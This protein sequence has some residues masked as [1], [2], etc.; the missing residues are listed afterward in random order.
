MN[1]KM[2]KAYLDADADSVMLC[3]LDHTIVYMN[4]SAITHFARAGGEALV[5]KSLMACHNANSQK[6]IQKIVDWFSK[7]PDNNVVHTYYNP[8]DK[9][10]V[11]MVALRDDTG[12]L[13]G[14]YEKHV[15]S[16]RDESPCYNLE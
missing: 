15:P 14:Y 9:K 7:S 3:A 5:G 16:E 4:P 2:F 12:E 10:E 6:L 8:R 1:K 11:Y 13:I